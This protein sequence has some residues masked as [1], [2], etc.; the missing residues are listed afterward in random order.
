MSRLIYVVLGGFLGFACPIYT[1]FV[2]QL[3]GRKVLR[4]PV[5]I[6]VIP[7]QALTSIEVKNENNQALESNDA[8]AILKIPQAIMKLSPF[9][10]NMMNDVG[11]GDV[12]SDGVNVTILE[13]MEF[14]TIHALASSWN[15]LSQLQPQLISK[16]KGQEDVI[17]ELAQELIYK[18][19]PYTLEQFCSL[20]TVTNFLD[21]QPMIYALSK[22]IAARIQTFDDI[23]TVLQFD[24]IPNLRALIS[25]HVLADKGNDN[26][27]SILDDLC[28]HSLGKGEK[29]LLF[30]Y[31]YDNRGTMDSLVR[32]KCSLNQQG[33]IAFVYGSHDNLLGRYDYAKRTILHDDVNAYHHCALSSDSKYIALITGRGNGIIT[34]FAL[35]K[36][37][38][39]KVRNYSHSNPAF[40]PDNRVL[41]MGVGREGDVTIK[42][43]DIEKEEFLAPISFAS[44]KI[45]YLEFDEFNRSHLMVK[46]NGE[47][48]CGLYDYANS[49]QLLD[50]SY[51]KPS[52]KEAFGIYDIYGAIHQGALDCEA[53]QNAQRLAFSTENSDKEM[54]MERMLAEDAVNYRALAL[55][56]PGKPAN[57]G[58]LVL[59][60]IIPNDVRALIKDFNKP[61][62]NQEVLLKQALYLRAA[63]I[64]QWDPKAVPEIEKLFAGADISCE[65]NENSINPIALAGIKSRPLTELE[66]NGP[67]S[68]REQMEIQKPTLPPSYRRFVR[69]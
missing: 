31:E 28:A 54:F 23:G 1:M 43:F 18:E 65:K 44:E 49:M 53:L 67:T 36:E 69:K 12:V 40:S 29:R 62:C 24:I 8:M 27:K 60:D 52:R 50:D 48:R 19:K 64:K 25:H 61:I 57:Y 2:G 55:L 17:D 5:T 35:E 38:E 51:A 66:S 3:S 46:Y 15:K 26:K 21:L 59:V 14:N 6:K 33:D 7:N 41:L 34:D 56:H 30:E 13:P 32:T 4:Q 37:I 47:K 10:D 20:I 22:A 68:W 9:L 16:N 45:D 39:Y 58:Q 11:I 42:Q 63:K